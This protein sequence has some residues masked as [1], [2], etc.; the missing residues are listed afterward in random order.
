MC[1][2]E[3]LARSAICQDLLGVW[4]CGRSTV[5]LVE[6]YKEIFKESVQEAAI[7]PGLDIL[8]ESGVEDHVLGIICNLVCV[9]LKLLLEG[10]EGVVGVGAKVCGYV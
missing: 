5:S 10:E 9:I 6:L 8:P 2:G 3:V 1:F 4:N 7:S